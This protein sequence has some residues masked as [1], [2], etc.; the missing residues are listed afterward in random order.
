MHEE[1][2]DKAPAATQKP[3]WQPGNRPF[4][5]CCLHC[6]Y[7][8]WCKS[9]WLCR[10]ITHAAALALGRTP[11]KHQGA[12]HATY[13]VARR[14]D[15]FEEFIRLVDFGGQ[16][17]HQIRLPCKLGRDEHLAAQELGAALPEYA[18]PL[19][20]RR[21]TRSTIPWLLLRSAERVKH[22]EAK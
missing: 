21:P 4:Q 17:F 6:R 7:A 18:E 5:Q 1:F 2:L 16:Y 19:N 11:A 20:G 8:H 13:P 15:S 14:R 10:P 12:T 3:I 9:R 22:E